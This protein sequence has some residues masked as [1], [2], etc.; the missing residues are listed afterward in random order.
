MMAFAM[1]TEIHK[2]MMWEMKM[3]CCE[4]NNEESCSD[5][6]CFSSDKELISIFSN[7]NQYKKILKVKIISFINIFDFSSKFL[8]N[9]NLLKTNSP[10]NIIQKVKYYSYSDLIKIIK[11]NT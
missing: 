4:H 8:E 5:S 6:C 2:E 9:K 3:D 10:P 1:Q 11:S 7:S